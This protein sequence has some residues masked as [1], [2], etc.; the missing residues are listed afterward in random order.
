MLRAHRADRRRLKF[1][2]RIILNRVSG[3][4]S[5]AWHEIDCY[6][7]RKAMFGSTRVA[8]RTST[9]QAAH[10]ATA[11]VIVAPKKPADFNSHVV[12]NAGETASAI[13]AGAESN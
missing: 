4:V 2:S 13:R 10:P 3:T 6:L 9:Q 12:P 5:I 7:I 1:S 8:H 11:S